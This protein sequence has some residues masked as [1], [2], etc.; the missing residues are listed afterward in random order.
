MKVWI[1]TS[2]LFHWI[3]LCFFQFLYI[4]CVL[5][6]VYAIVALWVGVVQVVLLWCIGNFLFMW[7][8]RYGSNVCGKAYLG[9]AGSLRI[10]VQPPPPQSICILFHF[11]FLCPNAKHAKLYI[12]HSHNENDCHVSYIL[13]YLIAIDLSLRTMFCQHTYPML[14]WIVT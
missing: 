4:A 6:L 2:I 14:P 7:A 1:S 11:V 12:N 13:I 5:C 3:K 8:Y 9:W 10:K